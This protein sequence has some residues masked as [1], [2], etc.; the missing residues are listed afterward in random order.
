MGL[1]GDIIVAARKQIPD[2]CSVMNPPA[3]GLISPT[4]VNNPGGLLSPGSTVY[5]MITAV[6]QWG[7]TTPSLEGSI[8]VTGTNNAVQ[9][10]LG[11]GQKV[12]AGTIAFRIYFG[13]ESDAEDQCVETDSGFNAFVLYFNAPN[14][15][16]SGVATVPPSSGIAKFPPIR[17]TALLP[18]TDGKWVAASGVYDWI[19][20][21]LDQC[22]RIGNGITDITGIQAINGTISY[23]S[24]VLGRFFNF[25]SAWYDGW[26]LEVVTQGSIFMRNPV[27]GI[28]GYASIEGDAASTVFSMWPQP[29]RTGSVAT[30]GSAM[31]I[32]DS[33]ANLTGGNFGSA[34]SIGSP[35]LGVVQID[36]EIMQCSS[37]SPTQLTGILRGI[38]G[39]MP[40]AHA[41][42]APVTE[43]NIRL[44]GRRIAPSVGPG[45]STQYL[46]LPPGWDKALLFYVMHLARSAEQDFQAASLK[47][48]EFDDQVNIITR[49]SKQRTQPRQIMPMGELPEVYNPTVFGFGRL[50]Q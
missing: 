38:S 35:G 14:N 7:E 20:S 21:A 19:N 27:P 18:E 8:V 39:T 11:A 49:M 17:N 47:L 40:V 23:R 36:N 26:V 32:G 46:G 6:N 44:V 13:F 45:S 28:T 3:V 9:F 15:V 22:T 31:Q 12:P 34:N 24:P 25:V 16:I 50:L 41:V 1:V 37:F 30:L 10:S 2:L 42:G 48:K 33:V 4:A 29:S 5:F 43:L